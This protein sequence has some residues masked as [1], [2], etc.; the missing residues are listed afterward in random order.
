MKRSGPLSRKKRLQADP[1]KTRAWERRSRQALPRESPRRIAERAER[2]AVRAEVLARDGH[3]CQAKGLPVDVVGA[4]FGPL[5]VDE[6]VSRARGGDY[7][8]ADHC[9]ALC[10][11]HNGW[12]E[13]HPA[14]AIELGLA[15]NSW[16]IGRLA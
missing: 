3:E 6:I 10:R 9:Q 1:D 2:K 12:K 13:D 5:E 14:L 7:L 11:F 8:N 4:C 16:D 15:L